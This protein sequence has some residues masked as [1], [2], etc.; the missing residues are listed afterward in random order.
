MDLIA[1]FVAQY[2]FIGPI[3]VLGWYFLR[4]PWD[5]RKRMA[6]LAFPSLA[7]TYGIGV[8]AISISTLG[9]SS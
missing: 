5:T 8:I 1:V 3:I 7:L 4:Q 9:P 2:L 6:L